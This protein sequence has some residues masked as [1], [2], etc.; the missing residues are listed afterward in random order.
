[1]SII[2]FTAEVVLLS[3][4]AVLFPGPL[5]LAN[6]IYGSKGG[7]HSGIEISVG[8]TIVELPLIILLALGIFEYSSLTLTDESLRIVGLIGGFAIIVFSI[9]QLSNMIKKRENI[10]DI[11][12]KRSRNKDEATSIL[13]RMVTRIEGR[14]IMVVGIL[15]TA[16][17]PFFIFWWLTIGLKLISDSIYLFGIIEGI[18]ILFLSHIWMDYAWLAI[19]AYLI[20]KGRNIIRARLYHFLLFSISFL[21][22]FYGLYLVVGNI[23]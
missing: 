3:A 9:A 12:G 15:F 5:F 22:A 4:S 1:M 20:S 13:N 7:L 10:V 2:E 18:I 8:H 14:P 21:L 11:H 16:M 23:L 17:N 6:L 19:T